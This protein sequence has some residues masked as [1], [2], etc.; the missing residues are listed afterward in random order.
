MCRFGWFVYI[1]ERRESTMAV[2]GDSVLLTMARNLG[3]FL[4]PL[5]F[6]Y[7]GACTACKKTC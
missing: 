4:V 7:P 2:E 3:F 6:L 1:S 5:T